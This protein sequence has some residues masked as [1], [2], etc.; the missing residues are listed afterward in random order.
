VKDTEGILKQVEHFF[1]ELYNE[2][3]VEEDAVKEI[4]TLLETKI[5]KECA[6][7]TQD[8]TVLELTECRKGFKKGKSPGMDGL[9]LEFYETFWDILAHNLLTVFKEFDRLDILP[10]SFRS[11]IVSLLHKK[12]DKADLKNWRPITLLNFDCK[13]FSKLLA[14]RMS[15]ILLTPNFRILV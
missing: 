2:K 1:S 10:D 14:S 13:I 11:G 4:L 12:G 15:K 5:N 3:I 9:P 7:L 8:F 6:F